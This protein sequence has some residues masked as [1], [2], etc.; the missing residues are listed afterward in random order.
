MPSRHARPSIDS[1]PRASHADPY[2]VQGGLFVGA[3]VVR[4]DRDSRGRIGGRRGLRR[5]AA[6]A[7]TPSGDPMH[8]TPLPRHSGALGRDRRAMRT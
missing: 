7:V 3:P 2:I 5:A 8:G 6:M 4:D 1:D